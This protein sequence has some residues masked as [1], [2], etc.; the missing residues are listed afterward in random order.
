VSP[1][2]PRVVVIGGG[3]IGCAVAWR[4]ALRGADVLLLEADEPG[5]HASSAAAGMLSPLREATS[6]GPFLDLGLR[7][8]ERYP[9]F[10]ETLEAASGVDTAYRRDGRL[11]IALDDDGAEALRLHH[12]LQVQAGWE[13][14]LLEPAELRRLEPEIGPGAVLG[15]ATEHDHQVDSQGLVRAL[16]IAVLHEGAGIRTGQEVTGILT[17]DD[18]RVRGARL[19]DGEAVEADV[20]VV[21]AGAWSGRLDLPRPLPIRPVRGQLVVL[22]TIP[23]FLGRTTW[24]PGCYL[25]PRRDGRLL[26][27]STMEEVGFSVRVTAAAVS[28]L[29]GDAIRVAPGLAEAEVRGFRAALRPA[30]PDGLPVLGRDPDVEG[31][32]YAT[33]HF[34]NGIL[35]APE[36]AEQ[37]AAMALDGQAGDPAFASD[38]FDPDRAE[39]GSTD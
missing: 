32:I 12:D 27:G 4:L 7:S 19:S 26:V 21:A 9:T 2:R 25:V 16:W 33:G 8:L 10:V 11:D 34:R 15:L 28:R 13:S 31:L 6:P 38:R 1:S 22:R 14:R 5:A 24:G 29:L 3:V 37:V 30:S 35:L 20:V 17:G 36:T 39:G 18:G 23:P